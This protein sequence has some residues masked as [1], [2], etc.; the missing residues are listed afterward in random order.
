MPNL[1]SS[2]DSQSFTIRDPLLTRR[3]RRPAADYKPSATQ[4]VMVSASPLATGATRA[5]PGMQVLMGAAAHGTAGG[6]D[7]SHN[8]IC[9]EGHY[10]HAVHRPQAVLQRCAAMTAGDDEQLKR[11]HATVS[12][13]SMPM[14]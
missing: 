10:E 6:V 2:A 3:I 4:V 13:A 8:C 1:V 11:M 7:D 5:L 14:A 9:G 12:H